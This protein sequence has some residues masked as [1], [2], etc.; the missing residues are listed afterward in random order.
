MDEKMNESEWM[1]WLKTMANLAAG[2]FWS[3]V[4]IY[5]VNIDK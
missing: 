3:P 4:A 1:L 2:S 5:Q